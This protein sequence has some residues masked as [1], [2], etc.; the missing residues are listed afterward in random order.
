LARGYRKWPRT[1][2]RRGTQSRLSRRTCSPRYGAAIL[3][4]GTGARHEAA[5]RAPSPTRFAT[6]TS[7][8]AHLQR[9]QARRDVL[10]P[11]LHGGQHRR[12]ARAPHRPRWLAVHTNARTPSAATCPHVKAVGE[13]AE[14]GRALP[15]PTAHPTRSSGRTKAPGW[16]PATRAAA[17]LRAQELLGRNTRALVHA[18]PTGTACVVC[19]EAA[20][21]PRRSA[22]HESVPGARPSPSL[23][24]RVVSDEACGCAAARWCCPWARAGLPPARSTESWRLLSRNRHV[25]RPDAPRHTTHLAHH[26]R[27]DCPSWTA[28]FIS[29]REGWPRQAQSSMATSRWPGRRARC[30]HHPPLARSSPVHC[31]Q[32][33]GWAVFERREERASYACRAFWGMDLTRRIV[34]A[35]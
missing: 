10:H 22:F 2:R 32:E 12:L 29:N 35:G 15:T 8:L 21:A 3:E 17:A 16:S 7:L 11:H 5:A 28:L 26:T 18:P 9:L 1:R 20:R 23:R 27:L 4:R 34:L 31:E 14:G 13:H 19:L 25:T 6:F 24:V 33:G 30:V